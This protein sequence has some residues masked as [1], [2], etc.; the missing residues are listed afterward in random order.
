MKQVVIT[1]LGIITPGADNIDALWG[2]VLNRKSYL[3]VFK[4]LKKAIIFLKKLVWLLVQN[5]EIY[6]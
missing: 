1:G 2:R 6:L 4:N 3:T 5:L